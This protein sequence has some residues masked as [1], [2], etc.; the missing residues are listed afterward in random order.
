M[1]KSWPMREAG[2]DHPRQR[3]RREGDPRVSE[4]GEGKGRGLLAE[5]LQLVSAWRP[6]VEPLPDHGGNHRKWLFYP[7]YLCPETP[8]SCDLICTD[9]SYPF[10]SRLPHRLLLPLPPEQMALSRRRW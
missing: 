10:L 2:N 9:P 4:V 7:L 1:R 3:A 5:A 8:S 6:W